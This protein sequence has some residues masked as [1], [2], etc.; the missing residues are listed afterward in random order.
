MLNIL[1]NSF[2]VLIHYNEL[3]AIVI[4][5]FTYMHSDYMNRIITRLLLVYQSYRINNTY[6]FQ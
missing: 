2:I 6:T 5:A 4:V 1:I 3:R